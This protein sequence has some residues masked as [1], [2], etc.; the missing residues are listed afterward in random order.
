VHRILYVAVSRLANALIVHSEFAASQLQGLDPTRSKVLVAQHGNYCGYYPPAEAASSAAFTFL[1]F[2]QLR[3][4]KRIPEAIA[5]FRSLPDSEL[6][7]L[8]V[9]AVSD[10]Q[11]LLS[12]R[13]AV[14]DDPRITIYPGFVAVERVAYWFSL[15]D[16][17]VVPYPEVF[18]SGTLLLALTFGLP[19]V[20]PA[21]GSVG[22]VV[23]GEAVEMY[24]DGALA[25]ALTEMTRGDHG[26]R[27]AAARS[28]GS[29]ASWRPLA[30]A[31]LGDPG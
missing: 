16:A 17:V 23:T 1:I 22:E 30:R 3:P 7:L 29:Q 13:G 26:R 28:A 24:T 14:G 2:G 6:R 15:A 25:A 27:R 31:V 19:V 10:A 4:Y 8:V 20:A 9:G 11:T 12:L 5:A 18:S 21:G